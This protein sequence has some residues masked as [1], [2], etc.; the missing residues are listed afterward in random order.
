MACDHVISATPDG[1]G[2]VISS[3]LK[4]SVSSDGP[5][6][7][8]IRSQSLGVSD[9]IDKGD[10]NV[11]DAEATTAE[12]SLVG[13]ETPEGSAT[14]E[15]EGEAEGNTLTGGELPPSSDE[16]DTV[17]VSRGGLKWAPFLFRWA[18]HSG[19]LVWCLSQHP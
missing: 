13:A 5:S 14:G 10:T 3:N 16:L 18:T 15:S 12:M 6:A 11:L 7:W 19:Q 9:G 1:I 2:R 8:S 4:L 17:M